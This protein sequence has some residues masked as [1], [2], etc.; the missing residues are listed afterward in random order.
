MGMHGIS[1]F[2][3]N[4]PR[5]M[6]KSAGMITCPKCSKDFYP[7]EHMSKTQPGHVVCPKCSH[8]FKLEK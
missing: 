6:H 4:K 7:G 8:V 3:G 2:Y 5:T 1:G